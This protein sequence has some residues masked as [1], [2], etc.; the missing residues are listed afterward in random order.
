MRSVRKSN[1][2]TDAKRPDLQPRFV[3]A[4][5]CGKLAA[6]LFAAHYALPFT[7]WH[8]EYAGTPCGA[9]GM[10]VQSRGVPI[11]LAFVAPPR[12]FCLLA[13]TSAGKGGHAGQAP[14]R[15]VLCQG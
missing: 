10:P 13:L 15:F 14:R 8:P 3:L 7:A 4:S 2:S 5:F 9:A 6:A 1:V 12:N 11:T